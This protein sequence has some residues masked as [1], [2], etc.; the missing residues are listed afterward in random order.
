M[1]FTI[2][3]DSQFDNHGGVVQCLDI[4]ILLSSLWECLVYCEPHP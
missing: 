3:I 2:V 4:D 1:D